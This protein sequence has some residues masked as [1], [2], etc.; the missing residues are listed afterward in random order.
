MN[1]IT[2]R[3]QGVTLFEVS[4]DGMSDE[5]VAELGAAIG[6]I[7][8]KWEALPARTCARPDCSLKFK[9]TDSRM[10]YHS[11]RCARLQAVRDWKERKRKANGGPS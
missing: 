1:V 8:D 9:A 3:E 5:N 10:R 6:R 4:I 7:I 2:D 11:P